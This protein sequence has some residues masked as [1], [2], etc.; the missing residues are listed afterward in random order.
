ML[1]FSIEY[2]LLIWE[3]CLSCNK[4]DENC[5]SFPIYCFTY[6]YFACSL[7]FQF[8]CFNNL[9]IKSSS[10]PFFS[11]YVTL[12]YSFLTTF[13]NLTNT[14]LFPLLYSFLYTIRWPFIKPSRHCLLVL[15][16]TALLNIPPL[17]D[18][19]VIV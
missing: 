1:L 18:F 11:Y 3:L 4:P 15:L 13:S 19:L 5:V 12:F 9:L 14:A 16:K 8:F 17:F 7:C 2:I 6:L 10:L